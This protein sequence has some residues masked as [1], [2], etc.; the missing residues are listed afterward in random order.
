M[1]ASSLCWARWV[2]EK[3]AFVF[4]ILQGQNHWTVQKQATQGKTRT[5]IEVLTAPDR[6]DEVARMLGGMKITPQTLAHA[7]EMLQ[8]AQRE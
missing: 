6:I 4:P 7:K 3:R 8:H 1:S 2:Q 5:D